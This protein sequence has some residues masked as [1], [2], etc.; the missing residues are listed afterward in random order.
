MASFA[1]MFQAIGGGLLTGGLG[2][3]ITGGIMA[4][5]EQQAEDVAKREQRAVQGTQLQQF[6]LAR[7]NAV[8]NII[9]DQADLEN[10][11]A[12]SGRTNS[13]AAQEARLKLQRD[14]EARMNAL[15]GARRRFEAGEKMSEVQADLAK[16]QQRA[17]LLGQGISQGLALAA[18]A[19]QGI[20]ALP[21]HATAA[22]IN[23]ASPGVQSALNQ[24]T[25]FQTLGGV[26]TTAYTKKRYDPFAQQGITNPTGFSFGGV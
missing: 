23:M 13:T 14:A 22:E 8:E 17:G 20:S 11:L 4:R 10:S 25:V 7:R 5:R 16:S 2:G 21:S 19:A 9:Q 26:P 15:E 24:S 18:G 3:A 12:Q 6:D 1:K